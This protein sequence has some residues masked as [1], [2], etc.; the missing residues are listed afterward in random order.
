MAYYQYITEE[1]D[2]W[3]LLAYEYWGDASLVPHLIADNQHIPLMEEMPAGW[4]L[5]INEDAPIVEDSITYSNS[6]PPWK[7]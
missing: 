2:R 1:G 6:L 3:D 4:V 7:Q 5:N